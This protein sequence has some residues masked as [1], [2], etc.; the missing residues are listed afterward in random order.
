MTTAQV[1]QSGRAGV[2]DSN[3]AVTVVIDRGRGGGTRLI[4]VSDKTSITIT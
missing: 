2:H 3:H 1:A 4:Q